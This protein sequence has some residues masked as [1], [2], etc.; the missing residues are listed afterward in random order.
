MWW[1][2]EEEFVSIALE[3]NLALNSM[4][5]GGNCDDDDDDGGEDDDDFIFHEVEGL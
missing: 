3:N 1:R 4:D 5:D 2:V